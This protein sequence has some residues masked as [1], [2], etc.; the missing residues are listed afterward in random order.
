MIFPCPNCGAPAERTCIEKNSTN[1]IIQTSCPS[2]DYL[3]V[4]CLRTGKVM[5]AYA[6]GVGSP[7]VVHKPH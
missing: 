6:P 3:M 4:S 5:E 2:C 1:Q 7:V